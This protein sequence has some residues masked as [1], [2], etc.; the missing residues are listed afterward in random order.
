MVASGHRDALSHRL[1]IEIPFPTSQDSGVDAQHDN[2]VDGF[3]H[4]A[5][6]SAVFRRDI[7]RNANQYID[8]L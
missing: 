8:Y 5:S 2:V 4:S 7:D 6:A 1:L 3:S